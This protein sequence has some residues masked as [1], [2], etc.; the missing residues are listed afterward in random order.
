[1]PDARLEVVEEAGH[2]PWLD[3]P[4]RCADAVASFLSD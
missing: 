2:L 4:Q 1:M 3:H